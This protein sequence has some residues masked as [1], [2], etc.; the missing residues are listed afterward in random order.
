M[1]T[2]SKKAALDLVKAGITF[3][4]LR[5]AIA[6]GRNREGTSKLNPAL[7]VAQSAEVLEKSIAAQAD[8]TKVQA[9]YWSPSRSRHVTSSYAMIATNILREF[10]APPADG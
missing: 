10:G 8:D 9:T 2:L 6:A 3:G 7:T 4:D 1:K 5:R